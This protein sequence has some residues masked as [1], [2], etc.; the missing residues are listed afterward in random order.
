MTRFIIIVIVVI[1][2]YA[3]QRRTGAR[4]ASMPYWT[5]WPAD[6]RNERKKWNKK[7]WKH[8]A[9]RSRALV[10]AKRNDVIKTNSLKMMR[11]KKRNAFRLGN[12]AHLTFYWIP[13]HFIPNRKW[14]I[15]MRW[16]GSQLNVSINQDIRFQCMENVWLPWV[17]MCHESLNASYAPHFRMHSR[18]V[19]GSHFI[20]SVVWS[21]S[22]R[23]SAR[24]RS[25]ADDLVCDTWQPITQHTL[26]RTCVTLQ[27][28]AVSAHVACV[29][30][31]GL[32]SHSL[33]M[34][35]EHSRH[36]QRIECVLAYTAC[37]SVAESKLGDR[38]IESSHIL[39]I[40]RAELC[41]CEYGELINIYFLN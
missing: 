13:F 11:T 25:P 19:F 14:P 41:A 26:K 5:K 30:V 20:N 33:H 37:E 8:N 28:D 24:G 3:C 40:M 32:L 39:N 6:K 9:F 12:A 18:C 22:R 16:H 38:E 15:S 23:D 27:Q 36:S 1:G 10:Y 31:C 17:W 2:C 35:Y 34:Y 7:K 21:Q 4:P 29:C